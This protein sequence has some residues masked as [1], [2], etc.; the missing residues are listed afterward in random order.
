MN[1][2]RQNTNSPDHN[3][4]VAQ[5]FRD[6]EVRDRRLFEAAQEGILILDVDTGRIN[7]ANPFAVELL[8]FSPDEMSGKTLGELGAFKPIE[9][10]PGLLERLQRD[11]YVRYEDLPLETRDG[12]TIA[13]E[14][15]CH[16]CQV[17]DKRVI[18]CNFRDI[19]G[20]K[21]AEMDSNRLAAIIEF[22][23]DAILSKDLDGLITSWNK[24]A[25]KIFGYTAGEMV[26]TSIV[27]LIPADRQEEENHIL[28]KIKHGENVEH[29][30]TLRQTKDGR[31]ID[32]SVTASPIK[33]ASGKIVGVSKVSR[34]I[35][36]RKM[37]EEAL[38]ASAARYRTLF[39]YAPDGLVIADAESCY[40]DANA[41]ACRM[42][43]YARDELIGMHARDIVVQS[44]IQHIQPALDAI[45]DGS[46]YH[47]EWQ[48]RRKD[49]SFF[50]AEVLATMMP[51]GNLLGVLRD[52]SER[53]RT[54][55]EL[56]TS[57]KEI[58]DLKAALD[59]HAIVAI[60]DPQ[61][62]IT[63][64][65]DKFCAISKYSREELLGQDHRL[66]NSGFHPKEFIRELWRTITHGRVWHGEIKNKA[67]DGSYYWVDTTIVPFLN[68][69]GK[70]RQYVAIRADITERKAAEEKIR[71]FNNELEQR[72]AERTAQLQAA[73][74]ELEAF[75]Y[76]VSHD[77][78]APLRH[79]EGFVELL[80][81]DAGTALSEK[82]LRHLTTISEAAKR[83]G[84][85][86]DDLL[87]FSRVG[88]ADLAKS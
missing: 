5:A 60:T 64:V 31:L 17:G 58:G 6:A 40:L 52:I 15:V 23:D 71:Q 3:T 38:R 10:D 59:E 7:D 2:A 62:K 69:N 32:V 56:K 76:S 19:A 34:D 8:G 84:D 80:Q 21:Q 49:G 29:F 30:E 26:G 63:Y 70:P 74:E 81:K 47:R 51:D 46:D 75:S 42:L 82:S 9:P 73:N 12:R 53:R 48:F 87:A 1:I 79:V 24:G 36:E 55:N 50:T 78:R 14:L 61:G 68:E 66:I 45:K 4:A 13:V 35:S 20:R 33:D 16:I 85:L 65:N 54:E 57:L 41:S 77:L 67:K 11:G 39:D 18:H 44:E 83:M 37:A 88:R 72:V 25:E 86:I 22:S 28:E 27:R 43:G